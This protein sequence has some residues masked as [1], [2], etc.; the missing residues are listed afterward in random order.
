M[1]K[2]FSATLLLATIVLAS[3]GGTAPTPENAGKAMAETACL[4]FDPSFTADTDIG[5]ATIEIMNK[6]GFSDTDVIDTYLTSVRG[7][8]DENLVKEATRVQ[9][10]ASCG[11]ALTDSGM[12]AADLA[13]AMLSE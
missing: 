5:T 1:P 8:E 7:T 6:Y 11:Q 10:E 2:A 12:T 3:C 13:E 9:L 4:L